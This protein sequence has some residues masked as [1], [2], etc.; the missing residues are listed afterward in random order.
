MVRVVVAMMV[1]VVHSVEDSQEDSTGAFEVEDTG[2]AEVMPT[3]T[4][5]EVALGMTV[6]GGTE[7]SEAVEVTGQ[8]VVPMVMVSVVTV[9]E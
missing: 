3:G 1:L 7:D 2:A 6:T 5:E 8:T 9:V 4:D